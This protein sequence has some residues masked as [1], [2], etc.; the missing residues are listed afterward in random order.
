M[1]GG[2]FNYLCVAADHE[3]PLRIAQKLEDIKSMRDALMSEGATDAADATGEIVSMIEK[4]F[5]EL[6]SKAS[7]LY[8]LWEAMEWYYSGDW[9]KEDL[10][11]ALKEYRDAVLSDRVKAGPLDRLRRLAILLSDAP[12]APPGGEILA[13]VVSDL[14][15]RGYDV[16]W[17]E[18]DQCWRFGRITEREVSD[19]ES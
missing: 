17:I 5:D 9:G 14:R 4:F 10:D 13:N 18:R 8:P 6:E 16:S 7:K 2:S 19:S 3:E 11:E 12:A 1:S 15:S